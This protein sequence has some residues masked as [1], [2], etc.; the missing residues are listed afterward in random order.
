[1][2]SLAIFFFGGIFFI[3]CTSKTDTSP[4]KNSF[5][6]D[7]NLIPAH[8][9]N[10]EN[11]SVVSPKE[12]PD[13]TISIRKDGVFTSTKDIYFWFA[14]NLA[15]DDRDRLFVE[16]GGEMGQA[17]ILVFN[18]D[19]SYVT[20]VGRYGRGPGEFE[21]IQDLQIWENRLYVLGKFDMHIFNLDD[22]SLIETFVIK[23]NSIS[24]KSIL[25][26][27]NPGQQF[28]VLNKNSLL[29]GFETPLP[30]KI[31]K[32]RDSLYFAHV[33]SAGNVHPKLFWKARAFTFFNTSEE[34]KFPRL[35]PFTLPFTRSSQLA[36]SKNRLYSNWNEEILIK[37]L[38]EKG[39]HQKSLFIPFKNA[40]LP[41]KEAY[42]MASHKERIDVLKEESIPTSWPAVHRIHTDD[43]NRLWISTITS[44]D[45]MFVWYV[46][47]RDLE[48]LATFNLKGERKERQAWHPKDLAIKNDY[49]YQIQHTDVHESG[50]I[51]RYKIDWLN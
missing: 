42:A 40:P 18:K 9:Q 23:M 4:Q 25:R 49:L 30:L 51:I 16:T 41:E 31:Q 10:L 7:S 43:A 37:Q 26:K 35:L 27:K 1:M 48:P 32:N 21:M 47:D 14:G 6:S 12:F 20:T 44:N 2:K 17:G 36:I 34:P 24:K 19:G 11:V 45:S 29:L 3:S 13:H 38:D 46:L 28:Y 15:V 8:I 5:L 22:F 39:R 50:K 33:D